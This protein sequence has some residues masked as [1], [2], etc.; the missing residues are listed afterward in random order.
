MV[1]TVAAA[2]ETLI[3][4]VADS[5]ATITL[6]RP[7]RMNAYTALMGRE[8]AAAMRRCDE[9]DEVRAV[10]VTG[11]GRAFCAGLDLDSG[12]DAFSPDSLKQHEQGRG[13]GRSPIDVRK[14]VIAAM[15]GHAVGIGLTIAMQ[16]DIRIAAEEGKY[17]FVFV[18]RG[19]VPENNSNWILPRVVGSAVAAELMLTGRIFSGTEAAALG[20][21]GRALPAAEVLPAARALAEQIRDNT[22]PVSVALTKQLLWHALESTRMQSLAAERALLGWVGAQPDATE[23]VQS[24]AEKRPPRWSLRVSTDLPDWPAT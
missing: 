16:C 4:D 24:F 3:L 2:F 18:S 19:I 6:N 9:D 5:I 8:L 11:A 13:E 17:G 15:N 21:A 22:A 7:E 23:G 12:G 1:E 20:V 10:V 14:P